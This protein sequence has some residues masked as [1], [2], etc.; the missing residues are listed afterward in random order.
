MEEQGFYEVETPM[1]QGIMGGANARPF[2]THH[3]A[4]DM[5]F[6][7]RIATE[8]PLKRLLVGGFE[9][10]YEI[11][12]I[13]RNEGMDPYH[14]PEFTTIEAYQAF[15]DLEGMM[16]LTQGLIHGGMR[17]AAGHLPG[18]RSRSVRQLGA[19]HHVR[20]CFRAFR[21]RGQLCP[22]P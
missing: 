6:Y 17:H 7:L 1:L 16:D 9:R 4:L 5:D 2:V 18:C 22:H 11:G 21:R 15:T 14:N 8:L 13:F 3:N 19:P 20:S 10:V 12:R